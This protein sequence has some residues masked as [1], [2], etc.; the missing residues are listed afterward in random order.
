MKIAL[1]G[2]VHA[3]LPALLAGITHAEKQGVAHIWHIGDFPGYGAFPNEIVQQLRRRQAL[4]VIGNYDRKVLKFKR[5]AET[6]RRKKRPEK[7]LAFKRMRLHRCRG[8]AELLTHSR[9]LKGWLRATFQP[10]NL[11]NTQKGG[12]PC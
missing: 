2:D 3:N 6:W 9:R 12:I 8:A 7:F 4:S 11:E 10:S 1:I 5:R